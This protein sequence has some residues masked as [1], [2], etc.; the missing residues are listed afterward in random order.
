MKDRIDQYAKSFHSR[1]MN[2]YQSIDVCT[3]HSYSFKLIKSNFSLLGYKAPPII[4]NTKTSR[5][6][7]ASILLNH[8]DLSHCISDSSEGRTAL[9]ALIKCLKVA[10][11]SDNANEQLLKSG[12]SQLIPVLQQYQQKLVQS[13]F[14]EYIDMIPLA[15][16]LLLN[17]PNVLD[18][19]MQRL[20]FIF[21][22]EFQ[23]T[24]KVQ[25][26][27]LLT[28]ASHGRIT[29]VGDRNQLI[30][31]F[32]GAEQSNF[33]KFV[34]FFHSRRIPVNFVH[35][36]INYRSTQQI[37]SSF[38]SIAANQCAPANVIVHPTCRNKPLDMISHLSL[39]QSSKT[40]STIIPVQIHESVSDAQ[41]FIYVGNLILQLAAGRVHTSF[42]R[43]NKPVSTAG[44]RDDFVLLPPVALSEIAV[45]YRTNAIG[46]AFKEYLKANHRNLPFSIT[47]SNQGDD[48]NDGEANA[49]SESSSFP[50]RRHLHHIKQWL[51]FFLNWENDDDLF[52]SLLKHRFMSNSQ[53]SSASK[54]TKNAIDTAE[55]LFNQSTNRSR[56][57]FL[58]LGD[59]LEVCDSQSQKRNVHAV[60]TYP[61]AKAL[62][63]WYLSIQSMI[64]E[65]KCQEITLQRL[66]DKI[67]MISNIQSD[68]DVSIN[69]MGKSRQAKSYNRN[70]MSGIK[71]G[72]EDI[73]TSRSNRSVMDSLNSNE[74]DEELQRVVNF[75][76]DLKA[77]VSQFLKNR[78]GVSA[79]YHAEGVRFHLSSFLAHIQSLLESGR[80]L[81][82]FVYKG[83]QGE[84]VPESGSQKDSYTCSRTQGKVF[85]GTIHKAKGKE[86]R[87]VILLK[88]NDDVFRFTSAPNRF[89][90]SFEAEGMDESDGDD[91]LAAG[92]MDDERRLLF[93]ALSRAKELLIVSFVGKSR[94]RQD[95]E[96]TR[97]L[98]PLL[99]MAGSKRQEALTAGDRENVLPMDADNC[100]VVYTYNHDLTWM[101]SQQSPSFAN[102]NYQQ[103]NSQA[104]EYYVPYSTQQF[105]DSATT[106]IKKLC[107]N[108]EQN[109][110]MRAPLEAMGNQPNSFQFHRR[111]SSA[112]SVS[113]IL[114]SSCINNAP[115]S[116][117][118]NPIMAASAIATAFPLPF[119]NASA[120]SS[121]HGSLKYSSSD[122]ISHLA[123]VRQSNWPYA[124]QVETTSN[125]YTK[126][127]GN[128]THKRSYSYSLP[129]SGGNV[130]MS[131]N[132]SS[133][134]TVDLKQGRHYEIERSS[135]KPPVHIESG[136]Q[137]FGFFKANGEQIQRPS[138]YY[139]K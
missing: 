22:D 26:K 31:G 128:I 43:S 55:L 94:E 101:K 134:A 33:A 45:L 17:H 119:S 65:L 116:T 4:C 112:S 86:W 85:L 60:K 47:S 16:H 76:R 82:D 124:T 79:K 6:L 132:N 66:V 40:E 74:D 110:L 137:G 91:D 8:P 114:N 13:G 100:P 125:N 106:S 41:E 18:A 127:D 15:L 98:K 62:K 117:A 83:N 24:N 9:A 35:L 50:D 37:V 56:S 20:P 49:D 107:T 29:I 80:G 11:M 42:I 135:S 58:I 77:E 133:A 113:S 90:S 69:S 39:L 61:Q 99:R 2:L 63:S 115:S 71:R 52:L 25:L 3:F 1:A 92:S 48:L 64:S 138:Q 136:Q 102:N 75:S 5:K 34:D 36:R 10:K 44:K 23:D 68:L 97:L 130:S 51:S 87:V 70:T 121:S 38:N 46:N 81:N 73:S 72:F 67:V 129:S 104:Q 105:D 78:G 32:Q 111:T 84:S 126:T 118:S 7:V 19:E 109:R 14:I 12:R 108:I 54:V 21:C 131:D 103:I 59:V 30:F 93:V 96:M 95:S 28:I 123:N 139:M 53:S 27:L 122:S 120:S 88:A 89:A 57:L